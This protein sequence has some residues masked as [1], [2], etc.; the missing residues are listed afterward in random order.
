MSA[1]SHASRIAPRMARSSLPSRFA[2]ACSPRCA[3]RISGR[4]RSLRTSVRPSSIS[5]SR[6][7]SFSRSLKKGSGFAVMVRSSMRDQATCMC[8]SPVFRSVWNAMARGWSVRPSLRSMR[9]VARSHSSVVSG[10]SPGALR[11]CTW[12][13]GLS[14]FVPSAMNSTV[15]KALRMSSDAKPRSSCSS[16]FSPSLPVTM[17]A[18]SLPAHSAFI[19]SRNQGLIR[20]QCSQPLRASASDCGSAASVPAGAAA[21]SPCRHGNHTTA[22]GATRG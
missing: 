19:P 14:Q 7:A 17:Y 20:H 15:R 13:S 16:A 3:A 22:S 18:A 10:R 11:T 4:S 2:C 8:R 5:S 6:Q 12:N 1:R 9:P 21:W